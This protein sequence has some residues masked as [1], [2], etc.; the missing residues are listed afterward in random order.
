MSANSLK[1][2]QSGQ[3]L[4][5]TKQGPKPGDFALGSAESRA[6]ARAAVNQLT[7][8]RGPQPGDITI[9]L[10]FLTRERAREIC[11]VLRALKENGES[12]G[13]DKIPPQPDSPRMWIK[14]P[15]G[16][17][18]DAAFKSDPPLTIEKVAE[19]DL[20]DIIRFYRDAFRKAKDDG[21]P[22][23]PRLDPDLEWNGMAYVPA[24]NPRS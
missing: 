1:T 12:R 16:F 23:P 13:W 11:R 8:K 20:S 7:T 22:L 6:A 14:W 2:A 17:D 4:S 10:T 5:A 19:D 3:S 15:E 18:S 24:K 21:V 9:N